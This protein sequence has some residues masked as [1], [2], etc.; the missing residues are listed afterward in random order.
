MS[1]ANVEIVQA[2]FRAFEKGDLGGVLR[3]CDE[4][5]EITQAAELLGASRQQHG[6][7]G[8]LEAFAIWPELWD[9]YRVEITRLADFGERVMVTT[10]NRGRGKES[11]VP[12]EM[13][14]TFLFSVRAG[15]LPSGV[16]SCMKS[17]P[18]KPWG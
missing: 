12:V 8:V 3:L 15:R 2:A 17:K 9:D 4:K 6:H 5:I 7:A 11:G 13:P 18:S 16:S 10:V 1:Q 14:F